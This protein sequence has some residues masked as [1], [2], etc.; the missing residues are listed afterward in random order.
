MYD[1]SALMF[2][3]GSPRKAMIQTNTMYIMELVYSGTNMAEA[4]QFPFCFL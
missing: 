1:V 3:D 2:Q 4:P